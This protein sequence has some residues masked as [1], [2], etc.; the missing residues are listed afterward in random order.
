MS[1]S[2]S[3]ITNKIK[4]EAIII[5]FSDCGIA[6]AKYLKDDAVFFKKWLENNMHAEMA[7][8]ENH[9]DKRVDAS[10]IVDNAKSVISVL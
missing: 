7:Y 4:E 2:K 3:E 8:M 5:G 10:K 6:P 1:F 9:F